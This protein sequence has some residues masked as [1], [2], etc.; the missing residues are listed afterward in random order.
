MKLWKIN[1]NEKLLQIRLTSFVFWNH[2]CSVFISFPKNDNVDSR[3]GCCEDKDEYKI[4]RKGCCE[5][6]NEYKILR[7][8][9]VDDFSNIPSL[10]IHLLVL[11]YWASAFLFCFR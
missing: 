6:K 4:L 11:L 2:K 8:T 9:I 10:C 3:K 1:F 7:S 5:D